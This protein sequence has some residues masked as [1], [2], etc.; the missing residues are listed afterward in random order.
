MPKLISTRLHA[1]L[2]FATVGFALAF[3]RVLPCSRSTRNAITAL[4]LGKLGYALMTRHELGLVKLIPMRVHLAL[5][6]AAGAGLCAL[7]FML[8]EDDPATT[9]CC[10]GMGLFDIAAAPLTET[11]MRPPEQYP[12]TQHRPQIALLDADRGELP[13]SAP[14]LVQSFSVVT[15][16]SA[17]APLASATSAVTSAAV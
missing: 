14:T 9:A 16:T 5:D 10:V 4:A 7:P 11:E 1:F 13:A 2:D 6:S 15:S 3:P 8:D 12:R 17:P